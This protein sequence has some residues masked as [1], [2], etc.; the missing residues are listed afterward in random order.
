MIKDGRRYLVYCTWKSD[1]RNIEPQWE[2]VRWG[3][4]CGLSDIYCRET[5]INQNDFALRM[6]HCEFGEFFE[7][8]NV[9]QLLRCTKMAGV[10]Y[11]NSKQ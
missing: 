4:P 5:W 2:I 6:D 7:L 9:I 1:V 3:I 10:D 8:N 11:G